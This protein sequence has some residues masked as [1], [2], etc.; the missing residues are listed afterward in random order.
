M[1]ARLLLAAC[2]LLC[3]RA[4]RPSHAHAHA[5]L[6][7]SIIVENL[8]SYGES[9]SAFD[10][11][12]QSL[13]QAAGGSISIHLLAQLQSCLE[14]AVA[15]CPATPPAWFALAAVVGAIGNSSASAL[16]CSTGHRLSEQKLRVSAARRPL[17]SIV[18]A[19]RADTYRGDPMKQA[20]LGVRMIAMNAN[21]QRLPTEIVFVDYNSPPPRSVAEALRPCLSHVP[22]A[23]HYLTLRVVVVPLWVLQISAA[24]AADGELP[25]FNEYVAKNVGIRRARGSFVLVSNPEVVLPSALWAQFAKTPRTFFRHNLL[26]SSDRRDSW[27]AVEP[28]RLGIKQAEELLDAGVRV[29]WSHLQE[30]GSTLPRAADRGLAPEHY[31]LALKS[32]LNN[33]P[34]KDAEVRWQ[35]QGRAL[36]A[37]FTG[38]PSVSSVHH[39]A[40]GDFI[41]VSRAQWMKVRG[42]FDVW[43]FERPP[44]DSLTVTKM[45]LGLR[46]KQMVLRGQYAVW[47]YSDQPYDPHDVVIDD[48]KLRRHRVSDVPATMAFFHFFKWV[49]HRTRS[50]L[51]SVNSCAWGLCSPFSA[52]QLPFTAQRLFRCGSSDE[53]ASCLAE[54][55]QLRRM[56]PAIA[57]APVQTLDYS[58]MPEL[59]VLDDDAHVA[60][61]IANTG[62]VIQ[63]RNKCAADKSFLGA[64]SAALY[65]QEVVCG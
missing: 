18:L 57:R 41:M 9:C 1:A 3:C 54:Q 32:A 34:W 48:A 61:A 16:L 44:I 4:L 58:L 50:A 49:S 11:C 63:Q 60:A 46:M 47:H 28:A 45:V 15:A 5:T 13:K 40:A 39:T 2:V 29:I 64:A 12:V 38:A 43:S 23:H 7:G 19:G 30:N 56:C 6:D 37:T 31:F 35:G 65:L 21:Q 33:C 24:V 25:P 8:E 17:L 36:A 42:Y 53:G 10:G 62:C 51:S 26:V 14:R 55:E 22:H 52:L 20:C 59:Q 27:A